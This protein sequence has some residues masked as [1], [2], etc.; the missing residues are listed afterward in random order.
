MLSNLQIE[1]IAVIKSASID[2]ENGFNV[3][4]GETGAGKSIV[5]DSLN[6]I[7]GERTSRDGGSY[8]LRHSRHYGKHLFHARSGR[9]G[10]TCRRPLSAGRNSRCSAA[11]RK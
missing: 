11:S 5:I 1:N 6:A 4:T 10:H 9:S 7:L 8:G 3:M 2:F